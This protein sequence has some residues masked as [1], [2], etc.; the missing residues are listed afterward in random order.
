[1]ELIEDNWQAEVKELL[2]TIE[3]L[4]HENKQH[5]Q[6][7]ETMEEHKKAAVAEAL[8]ASKSK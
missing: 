4:Q 6:M 2:Q 5:R 3:H 7:Q 1:M 8:A